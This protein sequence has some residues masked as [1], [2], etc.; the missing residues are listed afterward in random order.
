MK[1]YGYLFEQV[2]SFKNLTMSA[3]AAARGKKDKLAIAD[4]LFNLENEIIE[5]E[6]ELLE[7]RYHPRP[8]STF[9]VHDPKVRMICAADF[10]DRVVHHAVCSAIGSIFERSLIFDSYAC[11]IAKGSHRAI[12]RA[13]YFTRRYRY[14]LKLDV[15]KFFDTIDHKILKS[16]I[17]SKIKDEELLRLVDIFID[18]PVPW[19][20]P[21]RGIP[22]GNLTSQHFA[23]FYLSDLD[24]YVKEQLRI[25]GYIRYMDDSVLFADEKDT[26]WDA[27]NRIESYLSCELSLKLKE[28]SVIVAPVSQGLS[29]LGFRIFPGII[30]IQRKGWRRFRRKV[31][32]R[33]ED[34]ANGMID[35]EEWNDSMH[36]MIGHL[37]NAATRN[38]RVAFFK[39][40]GHKGLQPCDSWRQLE[41]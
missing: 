39:G 32:R 30:R 13:R 11:R 18:H 5:I 41:Q 38:L 29:F 16:L 24:H 27:K 19:T 28:N 36:S 14:F 10:R 7:K 3:H 17:R 40:Q 37:K 34:L 9:M 21:G 1:R 23:N 20:E 2:C 6:Q 8:Y 31:L 33:N 12:K 15:R 4:F 26:L 25:E 22:I 35:I